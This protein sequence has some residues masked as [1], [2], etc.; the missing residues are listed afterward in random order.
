[1]N[2]DSAELDSLFYRCVNKRR[3]EQNV[4]IGC[5]LGL[6]YVESPNETV[7]ELIARHYWIQYWQDGEYESLLSN[8][9]DG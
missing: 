3:V 6:W 8:K 7:A 5:R 2:M 4:Q 9:E 1:M